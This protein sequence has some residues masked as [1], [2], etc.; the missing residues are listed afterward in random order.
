MNQGGHFYALKLYQC[1]LK[2]Y[3]FERV[4]QAFN[5]ISVLKRELR[6]SY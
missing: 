2:I 5:E 4:Q 1:L 3:T 6:L